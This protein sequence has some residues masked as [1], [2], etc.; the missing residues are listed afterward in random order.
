MGTEAAAQVADV[1]ARVTAFAEPSGTSGLLVIHPGARAAVW[2]TDDAQVFAGYDA[3]IVTG[4]TEPIKA[5]PLSGVDVVSAATDF[6]DVRHVPYGGFSIERGATRL[7]GS[8]SYGVESDYRS[9]SFTVST[10][11]DFFQ[12]NTSVDLSYARGFDEVCTA[13][14]SDAVPTTAR[15]ALDS[16]RGCFS[17]DE[18]RATRE[19]N[20]DNFQATWTQLWT[21]VLSTQTTLSGQLQNGFLEN[22]YRSVVISPSGDAALENHPTNRAR[23]ALG[24][25]GKYYIRDWQTAVTLSGRVY[26]DTWGIWA[27]TYDLWLERNWTSWLRLMGRARFHQQSGALFWSDD[28]TGGEPTNGPRGQYWSGDR[29]LSPLNAYSIGG[30]ALVTAV[31]APGN[32]FWGM[33]LK[34]SAGFSFDVIKTDLKN[35]TWGGVTPNDTLA[36]VGTLTLSGSF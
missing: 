16:S 13:A 33:F 4:A 3:D 2:V 25:R 14:F 9:Q 20:L 21:P 31:G 36:L 1:E 34:S 7:S 24:I 28:Y 6:D 30:R 27:G 15:P 18:A 11:A 26:R 29:E 10:G 8:Y 23:G 22:P 19:V 17:D 35:F 32:R 5:G 12:K